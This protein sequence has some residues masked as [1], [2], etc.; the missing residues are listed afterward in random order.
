MHAICPSP[1][2][3]ARPGV[4]Q[5]HE[6]K[7]ALGCSGV[8]LPT[9]IAQKRAVLRKLG[10]LDLRNVTPSIRDFT[11]AVTTQ[12]TAL[13]VTV[14]LSRNAPEE[15]QAEEMRRELAEY[16]KAA[17]DASASALAVG[18]DPVALGG[19]T[20]ELSAVAQATS[21][22]T[23]AR[24]LILSRE[25]IYQARL[26]GADAVLLTAAAVSASEL[27]TFIEIAA[28]MHMAAPVEV[29]TVEDLQTASAAS[30]R[31][32]VVPAFG[33]DGR[34]DLQRFD[35]L[36]GQVT[37]LQTLL[38]R[39]PFETVEDLARVRGRADGVWLRGPWLR[40]P[41]PEIFLTSL[42][43]AAEG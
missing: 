13:S 21:N 27:R 5:A 28:S 35:M 6:G 26:S 7:S 2:A 18:V 33:N 41:D 8:D 4:L 17:D 31:I 20:T 15:R 24:D 1:T 38:I 42:V 25:Q 16:V 22:P 37:R 3:T 30:A 12:R 34:L 39:G 36:S 11:H 10:P 19:T 32:L 43:Q 40:A 23:L 14:E 9:W 29:S